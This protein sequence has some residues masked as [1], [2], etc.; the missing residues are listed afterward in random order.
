[1]ST[2][3]P[4]KTDKLSNSD[5]IRHILQA[6][7]DVLH[8]AVANK[9]IIIIA[10]Q[11]KQDKS[12]FKIIADSVYEKQLEGVSLTFANPQDFIRL[13]PTNPAN[14]DPPVNCP[15]NT[16][17]D[18]VSKKCVP[19][20][21]ET[22]TVLQ[23]AS[24]P[25]PETPQ[26]NEK[27]V[28][29]GKEDTKWAVNQKG[30]SLTLDLGSVVDVG[31]VWIWWDQGDK[32]QF[33]FNIGTSQTED[34]D[35]KNIWG[36][37][38]MSSGTINEYEPYVLGNSTSATPGAKARFINITVNGNTKNGDWAAISNV[39]VTKSVAVTSA[40]RDIVPSGGGG[41]ETPTEE[42]GVVEIDPDNDGGGTTTT[43]PPPTTTTPPTT[44]PG[45]IDV[46]ENPTTGGPDVVV[47][48]PTTDPNNNAEPPK[49]KEGRLQPEKGADQDANKWKA[50]KM[51]DNP[52]LWKVVDQA[53]VNV[54]D[55][56]TKEENCNIFIRWYQ[57]KQKQQGT[58]TPPPTTTN[59][60]PTGTKGQTKDGVQLLFSDGKEI[61][62]GFKANFR[63]DG[64]R[65]DNNVGNW[66]ASEA[67][68]YFRF[69]KDP[70][71]DEVSIKW[72]EMSHSGSNQ[73]QCYD[74]GVSIK[75]GK[76]RMRF[77]N[78][79]PSY[80]GNIGSGQGAPLG[81][82]WVGYK[83]VKIPQAD[84]SVLIEL[85][86]DT[87]DNEGAKPAN[88]WKKIYSHVDTKYKR[89]G[90]HPYVTIR[91]DDPGKDGQK[92]LEAKWISVAKIA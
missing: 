81:T 75:D 26:F 49:P 66:K 48:P 85:Y 30:A 9:D 11:D 21:P 61:V 54:A 90:A 88:Q 52:A 64:K 74:T 67:Q 18:P 14:T 59:P 38:K 79:H 73:V 76:T 8:Q 33:I 80:S 57:W 10:I 82:K 17:Y 55:Q 87:G 71:D 77:E 42:P 35:F 44:E 16:E 12:K 19:I 68:G 31:T 40:E 36:T 51:R 22:Y 32:R 39:K 41:G 62:E 58:T 78:P 47:P 53:G 46:G 56:F 23:I 89:T 69:T 37:D 84:G 34:E 5:T 50:V 2:T 13:F 27:N 29:D 28:L 20:A 63:D 15:P 86:Q 4:D 6:S 92:N 24:T 72:S 3:S 65:Y 43:T 83:G 7:N 25:K 91:V 1:M 45:V 70:V 60:P